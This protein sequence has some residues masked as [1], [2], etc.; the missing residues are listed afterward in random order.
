[1]NILLEGTTMSRKWTVRLAAVLAIFALS[2]GP[3]CSQVFIR[4]VV[5]PYFNPYGGYGGIGGYPGMYPYQATTYGGYGGYSSDIYAPAA[6]TT[7]SYF[8]YSAT[9]AVVPGFGATSSDTSRF[10]ATLTPALAVPA[11][12]PLLLAGW[13][14]PTGDSRA[15]VVFVL[16]DAWASI[17]VQGM[18]TTQTGA[19]RRFITPPLNAER[20]YE[21]DVRAQWIDARG[22]TQVENQTV[23]VRSGAVVN[24]I[25]SKKAD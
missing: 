13:D 3:A 20:L 2:A 25:F 4:P 24:V 10:R 9:V 18:P 7:P 15:A 22:R 19:I 11:D 14:E 23:Q 12:S 8:G 1:M 5:F 16:P 17:W 21:Y 6:Y